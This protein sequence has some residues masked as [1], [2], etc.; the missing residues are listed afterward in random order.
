MSLLVLAHTS[1]ALTS[2]AGAAHALS[3]KAHS[4]RCSSPTLASAQLSER[5]YSLLHLGG[6]AGDLAFYRDQCAG[7]TRVVELG[8][9]DGRVAAALCLGNE[10]LTVL[11]QSEAATCESSL[12]TVTEKQLAMEGGGAGEG[13]SA[14]EQERDG[15][16]YLGVEMRPSFVQK[17]RELRLGSR[18]KF[19]EADM[20]EPLPSELTPFDALVLSANTLFCTPQHALLVSRCAQA[21]APSGLLLLDVY[22]AIPWHE[23]ASEQAGAQEEESATG[24]ETRELL[25]RAQDETGRQWMVYEH[26]PNVELESQTITCAYDFEPTSG[27]T[28]QETVAHHYLLPEQ[29]L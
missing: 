15:L 10:P 11:Q 8:C 17:A 19:I 23:E 18:S 5:L 4:P 14:G 2:R 22:N 21:L 26:D 9:G 28:L 29:V 3:S 27:E 24:Q 20:L 25:V 7:C 12:D 6:F 1:L 16:V 13:S